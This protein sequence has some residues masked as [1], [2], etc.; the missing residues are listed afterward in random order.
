MSQNDNIMILINFDSV[1]TISKKISFYK[2]FINFNFKCPN[3]F[4]HNFSFFGSY[5]RNFIIRENDTLVVYTIDIKRVI[6]KGCHI[7]HALIPNFIIPYKVYTKDIIV[8]CLKESLE[9]SLSKIQNIFNVSRQLIL[10][11]KKQFKNYLNFI[12]TFYSSQN[13]ND[14]LNKLSDDI[15]FC[16]DFFIK[17]DKIFLLNHSD[18]IFNYAST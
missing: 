2:N 11:W 9:S 12:Y 5:S 4:S 6:C 8:I 17:F 13:V 7:T 14:V 18:A 10:N 3:C 15:N 1:N 16:F